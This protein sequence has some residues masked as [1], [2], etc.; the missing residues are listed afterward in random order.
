MLRFEW[1][2]FVTPGVLAHIATEAA[3]DVAA[4]QPLAPLVATILGRVGGLPFVENE[5]SHAERTARGVALVAEGVA[6]A[7]AEAGAK[8]DTTGYVTQVP[9]GMPYRR[10]VLAVPQVNVNSADRAQL[11][12]LPGM[13]ASV[14]EETL[15]E[16]RERGRFANAADFEKRVDG[17]GPVKLEVI[18][19]ALVFDAAADL[20]HVS[21]DPHPRGDFGANLRTLM[22]AQPDADRTAALTRALEMTATSCATAP[23]PATRD[24]AVRTSPMS[25][26]T[27]DI[28]TEWVGVLWGDDYYLE[29][30]A[31]LDGASTAIDVCMFHIAQPS[32][33]HPTF[34]LLEALRRAH[35]RGVTV[36]VLVDSDEKTDPYLSTVINAN[37]KRFLLDAGIACRSDRTDRL[38]H[39][40]FLIIDNKVVVLGSHNWSAG[41]YFD[42][43]D[44]TLVMSSSPL[45]DALTTRFEALWSL[46]S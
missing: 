34:Q 7:L 5:P 27:A 36:R 9:S 26:P 35:D 46:G 42:F 39:S 18:R 24:H 30:P 20:R 14:V 4:V 25:A 16:R 15:A 40:K 3:V 6:H 11:S 19:G 12:V 43:D 10:G 41:S 31:L 45:A 28:E 1:S 32:S 23:H 37:A 17:I 38:L 22:A 21:L 33:T 44:L 8:P 2:A 29:L 13:T